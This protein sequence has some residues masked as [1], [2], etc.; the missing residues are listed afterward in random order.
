M[1]S[2]L[3][4]ENETRVLSVEKSSTL[5]MKIRSAVPMINWAVHIASKRKIF[6]DA[7]KRECKGTM[8]L[9]VVKIGIRGD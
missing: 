6:V 8:F 7:T 1:S 4:H 3:T 5:D 2:N 9:Q